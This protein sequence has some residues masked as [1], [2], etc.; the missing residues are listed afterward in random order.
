MS[1][2]F[3][4]FYLCVSLRVCISP[5]A[6]LYANVSCGTA[7]NAS[8][9]TCSNIS[10]GGGVFDTYMAGVL[11]HSS[12]FHSQTKFYAEAAAGTLPAFSYFYP[13]WQ[14]CD[15]PCRELV[16]LCVLLRAALTA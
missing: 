16:A 4:P 11:R 10:H 7:P 9:P 1:L 5:P 15:H 6:G 13:T 8:D 12:H 3:A 14:A 2:G